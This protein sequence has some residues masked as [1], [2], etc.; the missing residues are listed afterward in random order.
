M[1]S[2]PEQRADSRGR[3][4]MLT[5]ARLRDDAPLAHARGEQALAE[6]VVDFVRAGVKQIFA[7][8]KNARAAGVL[9]QAFGQ[10]E[11]RRSAGVIATQVPLVFV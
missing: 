10:A 5:R 8:K 7:L 1:Q 9:S 2:R 3:D 4:T 11:R 6:R